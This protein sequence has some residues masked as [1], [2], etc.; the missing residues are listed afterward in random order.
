MEENRQRVERVKKEIVKQALEDTLHWKQTLPDENEN[1]KTQGDVVK[2]EGKSSG[3]TIQ[4]IK[5]DEEIEDPEEP[6]ELS[7]SFTP[8]IFPTP[9]RESHE[10]ME[11]KWMHERKEAMKLAGV[12][13]EMADNSE[14]GWMYEKARELVESGNYQGAAAVA[15]HALSTRPWHG[16]LRLVLA[17]AYLH[18]GHWYQAIECCSR[19]L[20]NTT[21]ENDMRAKLVALR[22]VALRRSGRRKE[23]AMEIKLSLPQF[24]MDSLLATFTGELTN[25]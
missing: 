11:Q 8:R 18:L 17:A 24:T 4:E 15:S 9:K 21:L 3:V 6:L 1:K 23:G 20:E 14:P 2:P 12:S 16:G 10:P 25:N 13:P 7:V 19:A 22:G 5:D